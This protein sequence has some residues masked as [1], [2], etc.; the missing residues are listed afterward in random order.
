MPKKPLLP[1]AGDP[2]ILWVVRRVAELD[3][4]D[5]LVVATDSR[6]IAVVVERA[7]FEAVMTSAAHESGTERIAE[8]IGNKEFK[9]F[10][11]ILNV[12]GDEPLVSPTPSPE[13]SNG[14]RRATRSGPLPVRSIRLSCPIRVA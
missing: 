13:R 2:L 3:L 9:S 1:L 10:D 8:V 5:R 4:C 14:S 6:E 12:Q 7:G 11:L